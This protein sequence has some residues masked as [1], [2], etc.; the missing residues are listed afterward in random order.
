MAEKLFIWFMTTTR[1]KSGV[2]Q[3]FYNSELLDFTNPNNSDWKYMKNIPPKMLLKYKSKGTVKFD[4]VI[5]R[6]RI[7]VISEEFL[8]FIRKYWSE[9]RYTLSDCIVQNSK[10]ESCS[11]KKY[12]VLFVLETD[13]TLFTIDEEGKKRIAGNSFEYLYPNISVKSEK[14]GIFYYDKC[15]YDEGLILTTEIKDIILKSFYKPEIYEIK[16]FPTAYNNM[17]KKEE[18]LPKVVINN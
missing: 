7:M 4:W 2:P 12:F 17:N 18:F 8:S 9:N 6:N 11:N 3:F 15:A 14:E 16:D 10:G 1:W 5:Y 13:N